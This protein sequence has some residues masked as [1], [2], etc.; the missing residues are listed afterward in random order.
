[1][2][3]IIESNNLTLVE[4]LPEEGANDLIYKVDSTQKLYI[5]NNET[6]SYQEIGEKQEIIDNIIVVDALPESGLDN[7]IYK[8]NSTQQFYFWNSLTNSFNDFI[9][10]NT[11]I[12][13]NG[14]QVVEELVAPGEENVLYKVSSTQELYFWNSL[15]HSYD[16][17]VQPTGEVVVEKAIVV[18]EKFNLLPTIGANDLIYKV[19]ETQKLY[20]WNNLNSAY[21]EIAA[22]SGAEEVPTGGI[23]VVENFESLPET[24][25]NDSLYKIN[26]T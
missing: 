22:E 20:I 16:A 9:S 23:I 1:V 24:G 18:V 14:I 10:T 13:Q 4:S 15:N 8:I 25:A 17:L 6:K 5:W 21:E 7:L 26:S 2:P 11:E 19:N 3:P 12:T